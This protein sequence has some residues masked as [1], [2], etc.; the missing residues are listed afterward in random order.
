MNGSRL[1]APSEPHSSQVPLARAQSRVH[2]PA[3]TK[4]GGVTR[5]CRN[6]R[7]LMD[8]LSSPQGHHTSPHG[9]RSPSLWLG[10]DWPLC[11]T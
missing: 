11:F 9:R 1:R 5:L 2:A 7:S 4:L 10:H 3:Y 8:E 6:D